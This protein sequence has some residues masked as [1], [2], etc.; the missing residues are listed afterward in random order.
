M[1]LKL[2]DTSVAI[3]VQTKLFTKKVAWFVKIAEIL[4]V[5]KSRKM[6]DGSPKIKKLTF[7]LAFRWNLNNFT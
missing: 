6:E 3:V 4:N 1:E 7:I 5:G 2:T